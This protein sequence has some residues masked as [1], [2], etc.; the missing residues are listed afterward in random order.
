MISI[1]LSF[2][3]A[4]DGLYSSDKNF[5]DSAI[6]TRPR[7]TSDASSTETDLFDRAR[8]IYGRARA[9]QRVRSSTIV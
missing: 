4:N 8:L 1:N 6:S 5:E 9:S 7:E 2:D 3:E